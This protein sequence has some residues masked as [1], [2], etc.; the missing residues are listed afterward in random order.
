M[1][2]KT[3]PFDQFLKINWSSE[4]N[5]NDD[6]PF[7]ESAKGLSAEILWSFVFMGILVL[8]CLLGWVLSL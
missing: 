2:K 1:R 6:R 8:A 4:K 3:K 5:K 7:E